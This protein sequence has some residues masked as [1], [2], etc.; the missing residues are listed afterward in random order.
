[1]A[2]L[3]AALSRSQRESW[4]FAISPEIPTVSS[5]P[6][7]SPMVSCFPPSWPSLAL[8]FPASVPPM[9]NAAEP[10]DLCCE[11]LE[12]T[13]KGDSCSRTILPW[14]EGDMWTGHIAATLADGSPGHN[15]CLCVE[16]G[17]SVC[18]GLFSCL[19][20]CAGRGA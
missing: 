16:E 14:G 3:C 2:L 18:S 8:A 1:M 15:M 11:V 7:L 10:S 13:E 5:Q 17:Y 12:G 6:S 9:P 4:H 20:V 19:R